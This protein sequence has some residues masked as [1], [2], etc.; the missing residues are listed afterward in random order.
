V[1][2]TFLSTGT[3][4]LLPGDIEEK[5]V[6]TSVSQGTAETG[7]TEP[8]VPATAETAP[9]VADAAAPAGQVPSGSVADD[10][11]STVTTLTAEK[12]RELLLLY[13]NSLIDLLFE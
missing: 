13:L 2:E 11:V 6:T 5:P 3:P 12:K 4:T 8:A 10:T 1:Y 9:A 7:E